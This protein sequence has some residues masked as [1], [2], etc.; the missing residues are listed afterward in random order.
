M[1]YYYKVYG[2]NVVS[3][4]KLKNVIEIDKV[5]DIDVEIVAEN[6]PESLLKESQEEKE[7]GYGWTYH[8]QKRWGFA[9]FINHGTFLIKDGSKISYQLKEQ[10]DE[11]Y[12]SEIFVC[13][14]LNIIMM[15][16][17]ILSFHGS[18]IVRKE[19]GIIICGQSGAGKSTLTTELIESGSKFLS[20]DIVPVSVNQEVTAYPSYPQRKLCGDVVKKKNIDKESISIFREDH[21]RTKYAINQSKDFIGTPIKVDRIYCL[22]LDDCETVRMDEISGSDKLK[23]VI[24]NIFGKEYYDM[25]GFGMEQMKKAI[26]VTNAIRVFVITRPRG[27][28]TL[29]EIV[30]Q[31]DRSLEEDIPVACK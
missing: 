3:D 20:D 11:F 9:H 31:L 1:N 17:G 13:L 15:Q 16:K 23:Y 28:D 2:L 6:L 27:K 4:Y 29:K 12:V 18:G 26:K 14:C 10:Y 25:M 22:K 21:E 7:R 8:F 24:D 5:E 19:K 30:E